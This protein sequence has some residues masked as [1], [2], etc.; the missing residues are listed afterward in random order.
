MISTKKTPRQRAIK[1]CDDAFSR[2]IRARD[3]GVCY[4]CESDQDLQCGHLFTRG[5]MATRWD[6][7]AARAQCEA[8]NLLHESEPEHFVEKWIRE[9]SRYEYEKLLRKSRMV[10]K[11][12]TDDIRTLAQMF[13]G[14]SKQMEDA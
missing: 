10:V 4:T 11:M 9:H 12:S 1:K 7:K 6:P 13:D 14:L 8:C 5:R 2:Y 3:R